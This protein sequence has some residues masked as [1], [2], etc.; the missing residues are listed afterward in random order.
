MEPMRSD[1]GNVSPPPG[2]RDF[3]PFARLR[4]GGVTAPQDICWGVGF[5]QGLGI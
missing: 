1:A 3:K 2:T 5:V 4:P